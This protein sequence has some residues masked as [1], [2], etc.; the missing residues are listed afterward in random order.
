MR[1]SSFISAE[2]PASLKE[3]PEALTDFWSGKQLR[4]G[5]K[6]NQMPTGDLSNQ[7]IFAYALYQLQGA[8]RFVDVEDIYVECFRLSPSRFGWR[9]H[10]LPNYKVASKAQRDFEGSRPELLL[11][12]PNGLA[13]QLTAEGVEWIRSRLSEFQALDTGD[14]KAPK[15]RR[16]SYRAVSELIQSKSFRAYQAGD[17]SIPSKLEIAELFHCAPDSAPSIWRERWASARS[18]AVDNERDDALAFLTFLNEV[19]PEWFGG[20]KTK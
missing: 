20:G 9:K 11:K 19:A 16:A 5:S 12:T 6:V 14:S 8:G 1:T 7:D 13:R 15:T 2:L 17:R 10:P 3:R 18:A 4:E